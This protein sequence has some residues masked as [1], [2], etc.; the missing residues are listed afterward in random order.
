MRQEKKCKG[1]SNLRLYVISSLVSVTLDADKFIF[2]G[3]PNE[4]WALR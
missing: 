2:L 1:L 4:T 3:F